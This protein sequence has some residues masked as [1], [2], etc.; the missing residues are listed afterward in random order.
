MKPWLKHSRLVINLLVAFS[1]SLIVNIANLLIIL[2]ER[3]NASGQL[4]A[5]EVVCYPYEGRLVKHPDGYAH[6]VYGTAAIERAGEAEVSEGTEGTGESKR[7]GESKGAGEAE[8]IR[9]TGMAQGTEK[10]EKTEKTRE[11][12]MPRETGK[13]EVRIDSVYLSGYQMRHRDLKDGDR[14]VVNVTPPRREGAHYTLHDVLSINGKEC[15]ITANRQMNRNIDFVAQ[16]F[17]YWVLALLLVWI[18]DRPQRR[19]RPWYLAPGRWAAVVAV[20]VGLYAIAPVLRWPDTRIVPNFMTKRMVDYMLMLKFSFTLVVTLLYG[21][22]VEL[23]KRQQEI[24]VENERLKNE[25]LA[26]RYD[27]LL[28]QVNPHFFFNSLNSLSML[29]RGGEEQKALTY[30]DQL[31]YT[32]RYVLRSGQNTMTTLAGELKFA[33]AY[34]YL[35]K[36]R[37]ADKLF[38]RVEIDPSLAEWRLPVLSLQPLLDNAVKHNVISRQHPLEVSLRTEGTALVIENPRRPKPEAEPGTGIGL[39]NLRSRWLLTTGL[40]IEVIAATDKFTV[41]LPLQRPE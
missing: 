20:V 5:E 40:E 9:E 16:L 15:D 29:V 3:N 11:T 37:F 31:S 34:C 17:F 33:E 4:D 13:S 22:V 23:M 10:V 8:R 28:N 38:F 7:A 30:I 32:F 14:L 18:L 26:T 35:F 36:I 27:M 24:E 12:E 19:G 6:I 41:R 25:N 1:V 2:T 21:L 39:E